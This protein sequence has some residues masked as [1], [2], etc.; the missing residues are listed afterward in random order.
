M[1]GVKM[2]KIEKLKLMKNRLHS[3]EGT[4]KNI[5][6]GGVVRALRREVSNL[7]RDIQNCD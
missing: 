4:N 6:C 2:N 5:K 1:K 7:E 3:L